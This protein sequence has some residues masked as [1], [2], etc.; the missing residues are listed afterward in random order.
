MTG[1]SRGMLSPW[2]GMAN[3]EPLGHSMPGH[4]KHEGRAVCHNSRLQS[5]PWGLFVLLWSFWGES[6]VTWVTFGRPSLRRGCSRDAAI[7]APHLRYSGTPIV[8]TARRP[9][10]SRMPVFALGSK[11]PEMGQGCLPM[12]T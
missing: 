12:S 11:Q 3:V 1:E 10:G 5:P 2:P 9:G 4:R 8:T 7:W 6:G